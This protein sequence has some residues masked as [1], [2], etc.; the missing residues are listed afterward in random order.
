MCARL[1]SRDGFDQRVESAFC[2]SGRVAVDQIGTRSLIQLLLSA[3]EGGLC[4]ILVARLHCL[5]N[6]SQRT[7]HVAACSSVTNP[8][9]FILAE[10]FLC[11]SG[12]W[13]FS[14]GREYEICFKLAPKYA[15]SRN[16][17][18]EATWRA[19][20]AV[21]LGPKN[22]RNS[23]AR[24]CWLGRTNTNSC[25]PAKLNGFSAPGSYCG[26]ESRSEGHRR[27]WVSQLVGRGPAGH[28]PTWSRPIPVLPKKS[29]RCHPPSNLVGAW[30]G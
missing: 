15:N 5:A 24:P 3:D 30:E 29:G 20:R 8:A 11:A 18:P 28:P 10:T 13:H 27:V 12:I 19:V 21:F 6:L 22:G 2:A 23:R 14:S 7:S 16:F 26:P 9:G 25:P 4:L 1:G 17:C